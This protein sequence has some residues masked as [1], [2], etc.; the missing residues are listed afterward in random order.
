MPS[1]L[2][3]EIMV[4]LRSYRESLI[5]QNTSKKEIFSKIIIS[6]HCY[7]QMRNTRNLLREMMKW[8]ISPQLRMITEISNRRYYRWVFQRRTFLDWKM[9]HGKALMTYIAK[10]IASY[11]LSQENWNNRLVFLAMRNTKKEFLGTEQR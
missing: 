10:F 6:L 7:W 11:I 2:S 4:N 5:S 3:T 9:H 1:T 8:K